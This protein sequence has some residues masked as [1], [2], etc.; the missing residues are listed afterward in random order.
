MKGNLFC[1]LCL[2]IS[3]AGSRLAA[4]DRAK[5]VHGPANVNDPQ[6]TISTQKDAT[7]ALESRC[8]IGPQ[9]GPLLEVM[10]QLAE[11]GKIRIIVDAEDFKRAGIA[12]V[13]TQLV[14]LPTLVRVRLKRALQMT[15]DQ[16]GGT[17]I[18]SDGDIIVGTTDTLVPRRKMQLQVEFDKAERALRNQIEDLRDRRRLELAQLPLPTLPNQVNADLDK[19][20]EEIEHRLS[21]IEKRLDEF[22][23]RAQGASHSK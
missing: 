4:E 15:L 5:P 3:L 1:A 19:R 7:E 12:D 17:Y 21:A 16:I 11:N 9:T 6:A 2:M 23:G 14:I 10:N 18:V 20:L 13:N 8:S 22:P